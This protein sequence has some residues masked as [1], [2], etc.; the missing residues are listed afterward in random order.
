MKN[1]LRRR[2]ALVAA[3]LVVCG[4][5]AG[6]STT[7]QALTLDTTDSSSQEETDEAQEESAGEVDEE[8][9]E[10]QAAEEEQRKQ[11]IQDINSQLSDLQAQQEAI[12]NQI[13]QTQSQKAQELANKRNISS[14]IELT[15][16]EVDLLTQKIAALEEQIAQK[17]EQIADLEASI[18]TNYNLYKD[19]LRSMYMNGNSSALG[20]LLGAESFGDML[21][22]AELM[23]RV[24]QHDTDLLDQLT[25]DKEELEE[26]KASLDADLTDLDE[27]KALL[28]EKEEELGVQLNNSEMKIQ[29][30]AEDEAAFLERKDELMAARAEL[31]EQLQA[32]YDSMGSIGDYVGGEFAWPLTG[33]TYISSGFGWRFGGTDYHTGIDI[34]GAGVNGKTITAANAGQVTY[35]G[36]SP[37]AYGNYLIIDHGGGRSTLYAH[38]SSVDVSVGDFVVMGEPIGK[39]GSTGWSTGPH[40][41]FEI[42]I[43]GQAQDPMSFY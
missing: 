37:N 30:Y 2:L 41:H 18:D 4:S 17:K 25:A 24:S 43:D 3:F 19:R 39:V 20:A 8:E 42:R 15:Q 40:L 29:E 27:S 10:R 26:V 21:I 5:A 34:T 22:Q 11:D 6:L 9:A 16:E 38:C 33:Y 35:V 14:Q 32:I 31:Q 36:Y 28:E 7:V 13:A 1:F 12:E 23:K